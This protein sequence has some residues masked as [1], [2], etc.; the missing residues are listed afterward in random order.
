MPRAYRASSLPDQC[1]PAIVYLGYPAARSKL[2]N[3]SHQAHLHSDLHSEGLT[4]TLEAAS[5]HEISTRM[6]CVWRATCQSSASFLVLRSKTQ[7]LGKRLFL[8]SPYVLLSEP[9]A[10]LISSKSLVH[11]AEFV[12]TGSSRRSAPVRPTTA[13]NRRMP[14]HLASRLKKEKNPHVANGHFRTDA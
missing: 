12:N 7:P 4:Y 14:A 8:N 13:S 9:M 2:S 11:Y 10:A 1:H 5:T 6:R 3:L